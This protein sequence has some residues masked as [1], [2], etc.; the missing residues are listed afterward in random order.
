MN[1]HR[2]RNTVVIIATVLGICLAVIAAYNMSTDRNTAS[3]A[4]EVKL[5]LEDI[6]AMIRSEASNNTALS[7][8]SNPYDYIADNAGFQKIIDLG[9]SALPE[10]ERSLLESSDNGLNEYIIA[11]AIQDISGTDVDSINNRTVLSWENAKQFQAEWASAKENVNE[12]V[13]LIINSD[14]L[15]ETQ[16]SEKI[17]AYGVLAVPELEQIISN[18]DYKSNE[19]LSLLKSIAEKQDLT[20]R[21]Q[22]IIEEMIGVAG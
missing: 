17:S 2:K 19:D 3:A 4:D 15:T 8:S 11:I 6:D 12:Q 10:L 21:D 13:K 5:Y 18:G 20:V 14:T 22:E 7:F 16:K 1:A 9:V